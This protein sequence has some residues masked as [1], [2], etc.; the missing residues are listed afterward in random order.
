MKASW[1][2]LEKSDK[3]RVLLLLLLPQYIANHRGFTVWKEVAYYLKLGPLLSL[4]TENFKLKLNYIALDPDSEDILRKAKSLLLWKPVVGWAH[5]LRSHEALLDHGVHCH[6]DDGV[7]A[8]ANGTVK[9]KERF[10]KLPQHIEESMR[11]PYITNIEYNSQLHNYQATQ[12][13]H[14]NRV[15]RRQLFKFNIV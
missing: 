9:K 2:V 3:E 12:V 14:A 4:E 13:H 5:W 6:E 11:M 7:Q 1:L 15:V 10:R 8:G